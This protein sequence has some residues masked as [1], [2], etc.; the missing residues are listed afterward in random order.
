M[1]VIWKIQVRSPKVKVRLLEYMA[2]FVTLSN[3]EV[4]TGL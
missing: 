4:N 1:L 3:L 2:L